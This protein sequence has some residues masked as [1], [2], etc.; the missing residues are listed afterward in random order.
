MKKLKKIELYQKR[1]DELIKLVQET[2]GGN[3]TEHLFVAENI[4]QWAERLDPEFAS[5]KLY[6]TLDKMVPPHIW[7]ILTQEVGFYVVSSV[8]I[9]K[10]IFYLCADCC[11]PLLWEDRGEGCP[12][13]HDTFPDKSRRVELK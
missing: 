12:F 4:R 5:I 6:V 7:R 8:L 13:C 11:A 3:G 10:K 2:G 9:G 1:L